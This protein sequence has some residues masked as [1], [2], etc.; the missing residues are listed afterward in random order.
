[1]RPLKTPGL[2]LAAESR[3][4]PAKLGYFLDYVRRTASKQFGGANVYGGGYRITTTL[5]SD[6]QRAAQVAVANR[7][8]TPGDPEAALVAIDPRTGAIRA[9][10]G[11]RNFQREQLNL[12]LTGAKG[13]GGTGRH[14]GSA[15]KV[16]TLVAALEQNMSLNSR[17]NGPSTITIPDPKCYTDGEPWT[18]SNASDSES[19][20]F[21]LLSATAHSVNTVFA[22]VASHVGP[23]AIVDVAN[24]MGIRSKLDPFCSITLGTEEINPLEMTNAY[25]TLAA[26]GVRRWATPIERVES[27]TGDEIPTSRGKGQQVISRRDAAVA[28]YALES[29]ITYGTGTNASIGRPAAGKTGTAQD[30]VD[31]WFCGYVPQ[32]ATCVWVGYREGEIPLENIEGFSAVYGGTLPALIWHDFM[33]GAT[34]NMQ[35]KDFPEPQLEAYTGLAPTP[36]PAPEPTDQ[37]TGSPEPT[38]SPEPTQSPEPTESPSPTPSDQLS[39]SPT[40][41]PSPPDPGG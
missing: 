39:P 12:A 16:F 28:T 4:F 24:R 38:E 14:A 21:T 10:I 3:E 8:D 1:V 9:M 29:V 11:G 15:F 32:L 37:P 23:E 40:A 36:P 18:L 19:G 30:Y 33:A 27:A 22:Q 31:A 34:Q 6:W 13:F 20:T 2:D 17:W 41:S 7:L 25:A 5:D 26:N 35:V